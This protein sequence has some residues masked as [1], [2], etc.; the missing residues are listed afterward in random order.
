LRGEVNEKEWACQ[1]TSVSK[2]E[3]IA[4]TSRLIKSY[5]DFIYGLK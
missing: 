3:L 5:Y 1:E 4:T 2:K